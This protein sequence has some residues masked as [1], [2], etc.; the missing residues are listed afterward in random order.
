M[1]KMTKR[2]LLALLALVLTFS[3]VGCGGDEDPDKVDCSKNPE[4][5]QCQGEEPGEPKVYTYK[6]RQLS[7]ISIRNIDDMKLVGD[8]LYDNATI[9]LH[10]KKEKYNLFLEHYNLK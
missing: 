7:E 4:H 5:E 3:L 8:Y 10:R 2:F 6:D 1:K 9:F